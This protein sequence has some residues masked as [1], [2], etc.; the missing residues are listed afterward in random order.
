MLF[1]SRV[2]H[3]HVIITNVHP[4]IMHQC[5][6]DIGINLVSV[7]EN[8]SED[9]FRYLVLSSYLTHNN[10]IIYAS[11]DMSSFLCLDVNAFFG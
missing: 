10:I 4:E 2:W 8:E 9:P 1:I 3:R 5:P 11:L 7:L 6:V